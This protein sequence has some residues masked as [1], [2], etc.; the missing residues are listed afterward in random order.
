MLSTGECS[1]IHVPVNHPG[2][3]VVA[4]ETHGPIT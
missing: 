1:V 2:A 3:G 4:A